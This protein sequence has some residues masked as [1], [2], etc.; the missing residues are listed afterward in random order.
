MVEVY[1]WT[2]GSAQRPEAR[3]AKL[4]EADLCEFS[5]QFVPTSAKEPRTGK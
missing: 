4:G 3:R 1:G 2:P 5:F